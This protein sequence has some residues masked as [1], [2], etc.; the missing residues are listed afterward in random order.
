MQDDKYYG[1]YR[2][3]CKDIADP[4]EL[5]RIRV[6]VPQVLGE[7]ISDWAWPCSPVTSNDHHPNHKTH[8]ASETVSQIQNHSAT[9]TTTSAGDPSHSHSVT[10]T[11]SHLPTSVE[12]DHDHVDYPET[13][14]DQL[15]PEDHLEHTNHRRV[16]EI[17][18]G[19]W[20]M[21]EGGDPNFPIWI[22][23]F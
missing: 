17:N 23:V 21:F 10:V 12:L 20:V 22:G 13:V 7:Q 5:Y 6:E 14:Y 19:V 1:V 3:I 11:F 8:K 15:K 16:P 4:E 2:G 9:F 18:Q